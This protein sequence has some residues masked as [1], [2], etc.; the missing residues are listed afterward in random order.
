MTEDRRKLAAIDMRLTQA[1][2]HADDDT[3][4]A[5]AIN[6]VRAIVY[7]TPRGR[8]MMMEA[9]A[10]GWS[11][12]WRPAPGPRANWR[13]HPITLLV[14]GFTVGVLLMRLV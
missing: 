3:A 1:L 9:E 4:R 5:R 6:D 13:P 2:Y 14:V 12:P 10:V 8:E 7:G 11:L